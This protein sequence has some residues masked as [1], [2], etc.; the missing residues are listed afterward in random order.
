MERVED[1]IGKFEQDS[2]DA[3]HLLN[4]KE[5]YRKLKNI[6]FFG[7]ILLYF[8]IVG[9]AAYLGTP[10]EYPVFEYGV[11][12]I[13]IVFV[14]GV[15]SL[16]VLL[17]EAKRYELTSEDLVLHEFALAVEAISNETP[18][19]DVWE[20]HMANANTLIKYHEPEVFSKFTRDNVTTYIDRIE[21]DE[22]DENLTGHF[23]DFYSDVLIEKLEE[24]ESP[25]SIQAEDIDEGVDYDR[26][27]LT[28]LVNSVL[29]IAAIARSKRWVPIVL[30]LGVGAII[31]IIYSQQ[32]GG[33]FALALLTAYSLVGGDSE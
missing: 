8:I 23:S 9:I 17:I 19:L 13:F 16:I 1:F 18:D 15:L 10:S 24:R 32:A 2:L 6:M 22:N 29:N 25:F 7:S 3:S 33:T 20:K 31:A 30:I 5:W 28:T 21:S 14:V 11:G 27:L 12:F 26:G 4:V